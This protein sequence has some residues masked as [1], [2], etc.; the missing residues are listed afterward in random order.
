M[1]LRVNLAT[2]VVIRKAFSF[3]SENH[4]KAALLR[5]A[6][7][8]QIVFE[9]REHAAVLVPERFTLGTPQT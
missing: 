1:I 6:S 8:H 4:P 2:T 9:C 3:V 5:A 7:K